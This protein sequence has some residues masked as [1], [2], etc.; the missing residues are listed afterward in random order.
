MRMASVYA[1]VC[2][3][4]DK[5][6]IMLFKYETHCHTAESSKC[7]HVAAADTVVFYASLG[8]AGV[9]ITDHL[10]KGNL[11]GY[12]WHD[13]VH[14]HMQGYLAAKAAAE[15]F[16]I[17]VFYAWEF[18][19]TG[20]LGT[21][22]LTYGLGSDWI[23]SHPELL[24]LTSKQYLELAAASG[25]LLFYAHPFR[26]SGYIDMIRLLPRN[27]AG[28]EVV[29]ANRTDF[30]NSR[31]AEYVQSYGL[32]AFAGSDNHLGPKQK[33]LCGVQT[34][35]RADGIADWCSLINRGQYLIFDER[36]DDKQ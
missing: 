8:Y 3:C 30:E 26:E 12:D 19:A 35:R 33:R 1:M 15:K 17:D 5:V 32:A 29:N 27:V 4:K 9:I 18:T 25:A 7:A 23:F 10:S 2:A 20:D 31:A 14:K 22:F 21:D 34:P 16:D 36:L 11:S 13:A 6:N 24:E 28:A